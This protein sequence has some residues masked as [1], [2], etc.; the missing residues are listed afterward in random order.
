V[1]RPQAGGRPTATQ[2]KVPVDG[3]Q[4]RP[5]GKGKVVKQ[6]NRRAHLR[7]TK[8]DLLSIVKMSF[9]FAFCVGIVI[10]VAL[11]ML[12]QVLEAAEVIKSLQ[13]LLESVMGNPNSTAPIDLMQFLAKQR[14]LGF[15]TTVSVVNIFV[16][17]MLGTVFGI[18]YNLAAV[19]FGGLEVTLEV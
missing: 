14:V 5:M 11:Y 19:L 3:K 16:L 9:L 10:F 15:I 1:P 12:Y 2:G 18:L 4:K 17:T 8:L 13:E 6:S 7:I